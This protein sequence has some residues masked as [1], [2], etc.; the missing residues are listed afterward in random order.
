MALTPGNAAANT[1]LAG[2]IQGR[3]AKL[4]SVDHPDWRLAGMVDAMAAAVVDELKVSAD[5][6]G[7]GQLLHAQTA[8]PHATDDGITQAGGTSTAFTAGGGGGNPGPVIEH[9]VPEQAIR[10][11]DVVAFS[12]VIVVDTFAAP[13]KTLDIAIILGD[14][15]LVADTPP[16]SPGGNRVVTIDGF[17]IFKDATTIKVGLSAQTEGEFKAAVPT[18]YTVSLTGGFKMSPGAK[19]ETGTAGNSCTC[20]A[21]KLTHQRVGGGSIE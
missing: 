15:P 16:I 3:L 12:M 5:L 1:G 6:T 17:V 14:V 4:Y 13:T 19:W 7:A 18:E 2:N 10:P 9:T 11:G 8:V 21:F 20:H